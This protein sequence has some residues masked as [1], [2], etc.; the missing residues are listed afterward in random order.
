MQSLSHFSNLY[1][2][3]FIR[4]SVMN[5]EKAGHAGPTQQF[6]YQSGNSV[7]SPVPDGG[8]VCIKISPHFECDFAQVG[9]K[10]ARA[11]G[12]LDTYYYRIPTRYQ[13][14]SS[15]LKCDNELSHNFFFALIL[16]KQVLFRPEWNSRVSD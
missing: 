9:S 15:T 12:P 2:R 8:P 3:I 4:I 16:V 6:N 10:I 14:K 13:T 11:K 1:L 7:H 5:H